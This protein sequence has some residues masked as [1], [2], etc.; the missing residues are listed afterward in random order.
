[1]L[2]SGMSGKRSVPP[3]GYCLIRKSQLETPLVLHKTTKLIQS[4]KKTNARTIMRLLDGIDASIAID[5]L[6][7]S[8][9]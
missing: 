2:S 9:L 8:R 6:I 1:M 5:Y 7:V 3:G 4:G